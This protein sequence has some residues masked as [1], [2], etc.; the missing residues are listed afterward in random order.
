[1][2][3]WQRITPRLEI[4]YRLHGRMRFE[5]WREEGG[6]DWV[7]SRIAFNEEGRVTSALMRYGPSAW[8]VIRAA[9]EARI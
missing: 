6:T 4:D 5:V 2:L 9:I 7:C 8:R 1:L 3:W